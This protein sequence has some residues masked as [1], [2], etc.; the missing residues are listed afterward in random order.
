MPTIVFL[1]G[2]GTGGWIWNRVAEELP[3]PS[4]ALDVPG[5]TPDATPHRVADQIV[6]QLDRRGVDSV[7]LVLHS[8]A[9][10]LASGLADRLGTRI[11]GLVYV[12]AV[13]PPEGK[14]FVDS[15]G[16]MNRTVL[17][18]LFRFNSRGL[19]PSPAMIRREL[20][21]DMTEEDAELVVS[22]YEAEWPGLYL[23]PV[24]APPLVPSTSYVKLLRD[25]SV[26]P[27]RQD[28]IIQGLGGMEVRALDAGHLAMLSQPEA[29][30]EVLCSALG[31]SRG[32]RA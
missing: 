6:E 30:A 5:R 15:F 24:G 20:C 12:S 22:R 10:V 31:F 32:D 18:L 21:N 1:H 7:S 3:F 19:K 28:A 23:T 11:E 27:A 17:R 29:L 26:L 9:G 8:L 13:V 25:Q 4:V 16:L 2:A 14:R